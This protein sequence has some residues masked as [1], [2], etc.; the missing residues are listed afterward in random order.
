MKNILSILILGSLTATC[1]WAADNQSQ[2]I[3][4][5]TP[6][7]YNIVSMAFMPIQIGKNTYLLEIKAPVKLSS[8]IIFGLSGSFSENML[9]QFSIYYNPGISIIKNKIKFTFGFGINT[10]MYRQ[11][12]DSYYYGTGYALTCGLRFYL[13]ARSIEIGYKINNDYN[14]TM[15]DYNAIYMQIGILETK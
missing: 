11:D 1:V 13:A 2:N 8:N 3:I 10:H 7:Y 5:E 9:S 14:G 15:L 6:K 4:K 12:I